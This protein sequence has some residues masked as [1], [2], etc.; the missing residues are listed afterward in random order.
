[1]KTKNSE[2]SKTKNSSYTSAE[3]KYGKPPRPNKIKVKK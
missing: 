2:P 3:K 1:M